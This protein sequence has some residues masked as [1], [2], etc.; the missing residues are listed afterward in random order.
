MDTLPLPP[1]PNL[2][3]YKKRA[4]ELV[5]A[6]NSSDSTAVRAWAVQWL[7]SLIKLLGVAVTPFAQSSFDR[8]VDEIEQRIRQHRARKH[9]SGQITLADTQFF[10][11]NAHG[12]ANWS[13][14]SN[15]IEWTPTSALGR[16]FEAAAEAVVSG[17]LAT[18]E[19]LVRANPT[20]IHAHSDRTHRA[21]LLHYV[22]ANG[23]E[24]FRQKTPTNAVAVA[25]LLFEAGAEVDALADTY[26]GGRAQTTLTLLVSSTHPAEAGL[27]SPLVET[28]VDH[29]A[30]I[31]GL[32]DDGT[33]LMTALGFGYGGAAETL[34]RRGAR[35]DN[36]ISAAALGR[37][38]L[39]P[40]LVAEG[41]GV[42]RSRV[43]WR[44]LRLPNEPAAYNALALVWAAEFGRIAAVELLLDLGVPVGSKDTDDMT[45]L[46]HAAAHRH[47]DVVKLLLRRGAPL[48]V[49]NTWGGTVLD[50]TV[51]FAVN[52][53]IAHPA[54]TPG[55]S[56]P[57]IIETL[58]GAGADV[59]QVELPTG[60]AEIDEI[61]ARHARSGEG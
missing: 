48:E 57:S 24:D 2:A 28:L 44:W 33:P 36:V 6:A 12:F 60:E 10:L 46:H 7:E 11:A 22:A 38:D 35:V 1:R 54:P 29:G 23:V 9:G 21:T 47:I 39:I 4:K 14:F 42:D 31:N 8:A 56:Y 61:L 15:H 27:Q 3:Q 37:T 13:A 19:R 58:I 40:Q 25:A 52:Q 17:D 32:D 18:L 41:S 20:L 43:G 34:A 5:L 50:S 16:E 30:V 26:G 51:Y 55:N 53:P 49:R 45:A 59:H